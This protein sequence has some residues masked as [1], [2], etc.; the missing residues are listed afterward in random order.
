M[1]PRRLILGILLACSFCAG[2][3]RGQPAPQGRSLSRWRELAVSGTP[4][5]QKRAG[6]VLAQA[7]LVETELLAEWTAC[8]SQAAGAALHEFA[9]QG[10]GGLERLL[11][12]LADDD[13]ELQ[14][15]AGIA[16]AGVS[17][18][19][20][21]RLQSAL[22][23]D[24]VRLRA[25]AVE[26]YALIARAS[27]VDPRPALLGILRQDSDLK[28][29]L[30]AVR[31]LR[32]DNDVEQFPL[33]L[34]CLLEGV[35]SPYVDQ[36]RTALMLM[37]SLALP[38]ERCIIRP[39]EVVETLVRALEDESLDV[40]LAAAEVLASLGHDFRG[41]PVMIEAAR[42]RPWAIRYTAVQGLESVGLCA[43]RLSDRETAARNA[44][45][46]EVLDTLADRLLHDA[47]RHVRRAAAAALRTFPPQE[48]AAVHVR[49][50]AARPEAEE[51]IGA[52]IDEVV[53]STVSEFSPP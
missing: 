5:E 38:A 12:A 6:R 7:R 53:G 22:E 32:L 31:T 51:E 20:L 23:S 9:K 33:F 49:L 1:S 45:V 26:P 29:R 30:C 47:H 35:R 46:P 50:A 28:V 21:P 39:E 27:G 2:C 41:V 18:R 16:L 8:R 10:D 48:R 17:D 44:V 36:R 52:L 14:R 15:A 19:A 34:P 4:D 43:G 3:S 40:K 37:S 13:E 42:A 11:A 24:D 25:G